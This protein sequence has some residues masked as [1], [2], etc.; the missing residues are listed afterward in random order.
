MKGEPD[1][2][3][4]PSEN[5]GREAIELQNAAFIATLPPMLRAQLGFIDPRDR[6]G[7]YG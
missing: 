3:P 4:C 7:P 5:V 2:N 1:L 6:C